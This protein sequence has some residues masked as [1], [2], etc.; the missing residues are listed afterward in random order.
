MSDGYDSNPNDVGAGK[1]VPFPDSGTVPANGDA[2]AE[3]TASGLHSRAPSQNPPSGESTSTQ[4]LTFETI[5]AATAKTRRKG[6]KIMS[7]R[8]QMGTEVIE[9]RMYRLRVRVD[10]PGQGRIQ[11]SFPICPVSGPGSLNKTERKRKRMEIVAQ[12]NS[13]DYLKKV[14]AEETGT[15]FKAQSIQ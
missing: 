15:T 5:P 6:Y 4:P 2:T 8:C 10:V 12:Y 9:G 13:L 1:E 7:R 11:R 14:V 3:L